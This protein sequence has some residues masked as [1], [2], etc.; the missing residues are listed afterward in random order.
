MTDIKSKLPTV[1]NNIVALAL[2]F[3]TIA[4]VGI[5]SPLW[6]VSF[7]VIVFSVFAFI[8]VI[9]YSR[10]P[11]IRANARILFF[12]I[13]ISI[14]YIYEFK[15]LAFFYFLAFVLIVI[16]PSLSDMDLYQKAKK[17]LELLL[18]LF[19]INHLV[20][21]LGAI[22]PVEINL[23]DRDAYLHGFMQHGHIKFDVTRP[24]TWRFYGFADEPGLL[25]AIIMLFLIYEKLKLKGNVILWTAGA[26]TFSSGFFLI[27]I[28]YFFVLSGFKPLY[29]I[30]LTLG[31]LVLYIILPDNIIDFTVLMTSKVFSSEEW[32]M[33][34]ELYSFTKYWKSN[35]FILFIYLAAVFLTPKRFWLF[36]VLVGLYRHH[37]IVA[38]AVPLIIAVVYAP[39]FRR[40]QFL[41]GRP[42]QS[43]RVLSPGHTPIF[44]GAT[45][46]A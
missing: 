39:Y 22:N 44:S 43:G 36:F 28:I 37:F 34:L 1:L 26:L 45:S 11:V 42:A 18:V 4:F 33:R 5:N 15:G 19:F 29:F 27:M 21:L 14:V 40:P 38:S 30:R 13:C 8:A 3:P 31:L 32:M 12:V 6:P 25:A 46:R 23:I 20:Y 41:G 35:P 7:P 10:R 17:T 2:F 9:L 16:H 24:Q